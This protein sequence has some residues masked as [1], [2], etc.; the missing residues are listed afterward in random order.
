[1]PAGLHQKLLRTN[2]VAHVWRNARESRPVAFGPDGHG[3]QLVDTRLEI[4][5]FTGPNT[6]SNFA[7]EESDLEDVTD[8]ENDVEESSTDEDEEMEDD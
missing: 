1:M 2:I 7:I 5:R 3:W 4:V 8:D 6:P